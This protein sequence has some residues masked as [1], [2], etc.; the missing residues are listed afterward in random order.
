MKNYSFRQLLFVQML[1][2]LFPSGLLQGFSSVSEELGLKVGLKHKKINISNPRV[3]N[4]LD[5]KV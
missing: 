5:L 2:A 1:S 3:S 4:I